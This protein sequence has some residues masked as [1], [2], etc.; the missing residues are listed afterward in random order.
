MIMGG[1]GKCT[2]PQQL[3]GIF[4]HLFLFK[5]ILGRAICMSGARVSNSLHPDSCYCHRKGMMVTFH[6]NGGGCRVFGVFAKCLY[7]EAG[8]VY[9]CICQL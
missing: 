2:R 1:F 5:Q 9:I 6:P 3:W 4:L 8:E 7:G